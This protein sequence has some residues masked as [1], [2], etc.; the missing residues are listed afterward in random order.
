MS[1][2]KTRTA[3]NK[4]GRLSGDTWSFG[5]PKNPGEQGEWRYSSYPS[6]GEKAEAIKSLLTDA[7]V[8]WVARPTNRGINIT[9]SESET[10]KLLAIDASKEL[11]R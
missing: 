5:N 4:L 11:A 2:S 3:Q 8:N 1:T 9:V 10:D 6:S 7:N